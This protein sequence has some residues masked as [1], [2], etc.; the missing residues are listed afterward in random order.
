M[1]VNDSIQGFA[2]YIGILPILSAGPLQMVSKHCVACRIETLGLDRIGWPK[3]IIFLST[4]FFTCFSFEFSS[5][6][7]ITC[8]FLSY[9]L[10]F[11]SLDEELWLHHLEGLSRHSFWSLS[12]RYSPALRV[13]DAQNQR[14][15]YE[16]EAQGGNLGYQGTAAGERRWRSHSCQGR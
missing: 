8:A 7:S 1:C 3:T 10:F 16:E 12:P 11:F 15:R 14:V 5:H 4:K 2:L 9:T 13:A 6:I